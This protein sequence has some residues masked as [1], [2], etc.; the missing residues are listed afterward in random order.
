MKMGWYIR[1]LRISYKKKALSGQGTKENLQIIEPRD[2][3]LIAQMILRVEGR[4]RR[5]REK[6]KAKQHLNGLK[7]ENR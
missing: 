7:V 5:E 3:L 2:D 1:I 4:R 6:K